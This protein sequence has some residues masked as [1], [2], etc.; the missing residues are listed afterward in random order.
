MSAPPAD[1]DDLWRDLSALPED[2]A[3][4]HGEAVYHKEFITHEGRSGMLTAHDGQAVKFFADRCHHATHTSIDRARQ[5]YSKDKVAIDRIERLLW[6]KPI[7]EGRVADIECWEI[8]LKVPEQGIRCFPGKRAYVSWVYGY[9]IWLEP[10]RNGG[11]K[12]SSAYPLPNAEISRYTNRARKL[13]T[14]PSLG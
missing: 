6:I 13:W 7:I 5:A 11:F 4:K 9:I 1:L 10:L 8:P 3:E 12:F 2:E 14:S